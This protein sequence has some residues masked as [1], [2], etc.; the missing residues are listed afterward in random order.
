MLGRS[1]ETL[2]LRM[3]RA[4]ANA[5]LVAEFLHDHSKVGKVHHLASLEEGSKAQ[6]IYARQCT[7][8]GST[9]SFAIKGGPKEAVKLA[10]HDGLRMR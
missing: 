8:A 6:A 7:G 9:F 4:D 3:E 2:A 1:L 10:V 5:R